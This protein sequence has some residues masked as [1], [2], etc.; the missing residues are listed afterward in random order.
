[1]TSKKDNYKPYSNGL[2][3]GYR[4][5]QITT[6]ISTKWKTVVLV[7]LQNMVFART[8]YLSHNESYYLT[9]A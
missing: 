8:C 4:D 9:G 1:M 5:P 6:V 7:A 2:K 3:L